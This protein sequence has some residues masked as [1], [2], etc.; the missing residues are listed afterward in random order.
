MSLKL[1][2][3]TSRL[4]ITSKVFFNKDA[5]VNVD[6]KGNISGCDTLVMG[7]GE[8]KITLWNLDRGYVLAT[9][10][11]LDIKS[12]LSTLWVKCDRVSLRQSVSN[13]SFFF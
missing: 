8:N 5:V 13:F 3:I 2:N 12:P 9:I 4:C 11:M 6:C 10:E 7:C 1:W